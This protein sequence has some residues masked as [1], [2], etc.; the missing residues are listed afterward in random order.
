MALAIGH[1]RYLG[2]ASGLLPNFTTCP[3]CYTGLASDLYSGVVIWEREGDERGHISTTW[4]CCRPLLPAS[5]LQYM[6]LTTSPILRHGLDYRR[7]TIFALLPAFSVV[8]ALQLVI[9]YYFGL[10]IGFLLHDESSVAKFLHSRGRD[11]RD[12]TTLPRC[13]IAFQP[14]ISCDRDLSGISPS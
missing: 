5:P 4:S 1:F 13:Q 9:F 14:R 3:F 2:F 11:L 10:T 8:W 12:E 7:L 6:A